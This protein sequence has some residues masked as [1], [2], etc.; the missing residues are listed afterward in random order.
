M[1]SLHL[2]VMSKLQKSATL[3]IN[4]GQFTI[5]VELHPKIHY[6]SPFPRLYHDIRCLVAT[7]CFVKPKRALNIHMD[8]K[9]LLMLFFDLP[10]NLSIT[11]NAAKH[12]VRVSAYKKQPLQLYVGELCHILLLVCNLCRW[13]CIQQRL[14]PDGHPRVEGVASEQRREPGACSPCGEGRLGGHGAGVVQ[15]K[16][17]MSAAVCVKLVHT[18][19]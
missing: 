13:A 19:P 15:A 2:L 3:V 18:Q 11:R 5:S 1:S 12:L 9:A 17:V 6:L 8:F 10:R 4:R 7:W 14:Q 16:R